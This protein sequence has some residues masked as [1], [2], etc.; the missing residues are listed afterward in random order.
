MEEKL[1]SLPDMLEAREGRYW[2][3][4]L[5]LKKYGKPLLCFTM[6]IAGPVKNSDLILRGFRTGQRFIRQQLETAGIRVVH[7]AEI[8][9]FTGN[10][11]FYVLDGDPVQVKSLTCEVEDSTE[12][13]RLFDMDVMD[14]T[15]QQVSRKTLNL[16]ERKC[17]ICGGPAKNCSSRRIHSVPELQ[18]KTRS[19]L[20]KTF[21]QEDE[22]TVARLAVQSLLYEVCT[23]PKP[24]LVDRRNS[25]SHRDMD[26]FTFMASSAALHPY[27]RQCAAIGMDTAGLDAPETF[28]RLRWAGKQAES[29]MKTA[30]GGVNTHK[31]AIFSLGV[32]C[33]ALGRMEREDWKAP[34]KVLDEC[35]AMVCGVTAGD[36]DGVTEENAR[37]V[38]QR[39]FLRYGITGVRGQ[40]EEGFPAVKHAGLPTLEKAL[41]E[42]RSLNDAGCLALLALMTAAT[43][44]NLI[45]RSDRETQLQVTEQVRA[46]LTADE[47]PDTAALE[48]LD[49]QFIRQ[50][51]SPGGSADLL[52]MTY[53]LHDLKEI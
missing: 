12:I 25:G 7:Q 8:T 37:T 13:G 16:S 34:E 20:Q 4:Q 36:F 27:F 17:L 11:A 29:L 46:M 3:Q 51:L 6:N 31:G 39:L 15:G 42:G 9:V 38:G 21:R 43:D 52:A 44:T 47:M 53:F 49:E 32:L 2:M 35:A 5:L 24:G 40:A 22:E 19:I 18:E 45:A 10:E 33:G 48:E 50:N 1:V 41:S 30:T 26:I 28:R 14:E 23:T